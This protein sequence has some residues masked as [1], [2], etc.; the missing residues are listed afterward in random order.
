MLW[1]DRF[2]TTLATL[3]YP[4]AWML[5]P[6]LARSMRDSMRY[7]RPVFSPVGI[8]LHPYAPPI[9]GRAFGRYLQGLRRM[10]RGEHVPLVAHISVTDRC[11]NACRR[12][13][14]LPCT[15]QD[16]PH[17]DLIALI[18]KLRHAGTVSI[19]LTGGDLHGRVAV[20]VLVEDAGHAIRQH[21]D[22]GHGHGCTVVSEDACHAAFSTY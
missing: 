8:V 13:S 17:T 18:A 19:A 4:D 7:L 5:P 12:C 16:P 11:A 20:V 3:R 9:G 21:L 10:A 22:D 6:R 2:R 15:S 1:L 14:N